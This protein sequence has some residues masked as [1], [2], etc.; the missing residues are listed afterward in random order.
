M[1]YDSIFETLPYVKNAVRIEV[2][3]RSMNEPLENVELRSRIEDELPNS[4]F[5]E[6]KITVPTVKPE[7]PSLRK[8]A[9]CTR[10]SARKLPRYA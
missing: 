5:A 9:F 10:S 7:E 1:E 6:S 8:S 4:A 2:S 3:G